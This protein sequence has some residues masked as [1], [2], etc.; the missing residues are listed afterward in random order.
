MKLTSKKKPER[1]KYKFTLSQKEA[2][3]LYSALN[4]APISDCSSILNKLWKRCHDS[5]VIL[6]DSIY[7]KVEKRYLDIAQAVL[8]DEK[9][10]AN[11]EANKSIKIES[12]KHL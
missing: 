3:E 2:T 4:Y 1:I 12:K 6:S 8:D 9:K 5:D 7:D 11:K 10:E